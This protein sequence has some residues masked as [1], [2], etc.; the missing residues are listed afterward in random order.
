MD[1]D[2]VE[3]ICW[4]SQWVQRIIQRELR[5]FRERPERLESGHKKSALGMGYSYRMRLCKEGTER[6]WRRRSL[7]ERSA[8]N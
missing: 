3:S 4:K 5:Y 8:K 7:E 1:I 6:G 2:K